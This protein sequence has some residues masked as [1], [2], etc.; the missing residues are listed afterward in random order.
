MSNVTVSVDEGNLRYFFK[1]WAKWIWLGTCLRSITQPFT[2]GT[3]DSSTQDSELPL[4]P[5]ATGEASQMV[6]Q[7]LVNIR[8]TKGQRQ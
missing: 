2:K 7:L 8:E 3:A 5:P 4:F 6:I 1:K